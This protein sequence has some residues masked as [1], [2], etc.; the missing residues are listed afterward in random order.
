MRPTSIILALL[1]APAPA[2]AAQ[3]QGGF[4]WKLNDRSAPPNPAQAAK[5]GFGAMMLV[6]SDYEGF[7][8]AWE[9]AGPPQVGTT[10]QVTRRQPVHAMLLFSGCRAGADGNCNV[11]VE[12]AVTGPAGKPYGETL[13]GNAWSGPPAP[14]Y[15]LQLAESSLGFILEPHDPLGTYTL[16]ATVTDKVAG[17][18]LSV[19]QAV[20]AVDGAE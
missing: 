5:D 17:T 3:Q 12:L 13:K 20:T 1:V 16:K 11:T 14:A 9:G 2:A 6:T 18:T 8:K 15:N 4:A 10:E 19:Q 7:W